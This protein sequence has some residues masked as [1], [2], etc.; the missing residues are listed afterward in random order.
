MTCLPNFQHTM[1]LQTHILIYHF[2]YELMM[3]GQ[4]DFFV[5]G[6]WRHYN[7]FVDH[8]SFFFINMVDC[9]FTIM[10]GFKIVASFYT[11]YHIFFPIT[12]ISITRQ[13]FDV[14]HIC[15]F[16]LI[17]LQLSSQQIFNVVVLLFFKIAH[18]QFLLFVIFDHVVA[19]F[20]KITILNYCYRN[21]LI[22]QLLFLLKPS[23]SIDIVT[24]D[25]FQ[26]YHT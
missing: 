13:I 10:V 21:F 8:W 11:K 5:C 1:H 23:L 16:N 24:I 20:P 6:T 7:K 17:I 9:C 15:F 26:S 3:D 18:S 12:S 22:S 14:W 25:L 19:F 2:V 4:I